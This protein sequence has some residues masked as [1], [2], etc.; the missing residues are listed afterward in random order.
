[1]SAQ[2][3]RVV[4]NTRQRLLSE[5][6]N[7]ISRLTSRALLML[8]LA[9]E[10][11]EDY[12]LGGLG[13]SGVVGGFM[14]RCIP[15][16]NLVEVAPGIALL[17]QAPISTTYDPPVV[18]VQSDSAVQLDLSAL[19]DPANPRLVTIEVGPSDVAIVTTPVDIFDPGTGLFGV[20][21][22][23]P[24]VLGSAPVWSTSAGAAAASPVI[25]GGTVGRIPLAVV[26]LTAAQ[27]NFGDEFASVLMCRPLLGADAD[28]FV[29]SGYVDGGGCSVGEE[30]GGA[31]VGLTDIYLSRLTASLA[32]LEA[33]VSG[34]IPFPTRARTTNLTS[35]AVLL[36]QA[37]PVYG[38]AVPPPWPGDY[39][40]M[41]PREAWQRNPNAVPFAT[42]GNVVGGSGPTFV[43]LAAETPSSLGRTFKSAI[44]FWDDVAPSGLERGAGNAP[45]QVVDARGPHPDTAPGGAGS[46]T[47]EATQDP[48]WGPSQTASE[49][50]YLGAVSSL[51][52]ANNFM[53][54]ADTGAGRL[55]LIDLV[56]I[57]GLTKRRPYREDA[58]D[59]ALTSVYPGRFP[60]MLV[61][62]PSIFP[63]GAQQVEMWVR[64][65]TGA[66]G[67][68]Q[69]ALFPPFGFGA[70]EGGVATLGGWSVSVDGSLSGAM[71]MT[72]PTI[73][74]ELGASG[75]V[76]YFLNVTAPGGSFIM[77]PTSYVDALL[78]AR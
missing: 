11:D 42:A 4:V 46:V 23:A 77:A 6:F 71:T 38:Y 14:V 22:S 65:T 43:S 50:V 58:L 70:I 72:S 29:P 56:Q 75:Q 69:A 10:T 60:G 55:R 51:N 20:D 24:R 54:Q 25:A 13:R 16:T 68:F 45:L 47:L 62:N 52:L 37:I 18:W 33:E 63:V 26:K 28:R 39:G 2:V 53:A 76:S 44:V 1:V 12:L 7:S 57:A 17:A 67:A 31:L 74:L 15:A 40:P 66:A 73:E 9:R 32:G 61:G 41:A 36:A 64:Y 48:T 35:P 21:P 59:V 27:A 8:E 34:M 5:D 19:I 3:P 49:S 30:S 78:A